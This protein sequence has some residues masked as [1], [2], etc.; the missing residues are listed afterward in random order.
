[1]CGLSLKDK[2]TI[3]DYGFRLKPVND[4]KSSPPAK[5]GGNKKLQLDFQL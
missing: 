3:S 5:A 4:G 1:M 2:T